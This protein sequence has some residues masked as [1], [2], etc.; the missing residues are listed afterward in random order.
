MLKGIQA[1][2]AAWQTARRLGLYSRNESKEDISTT[3]LKYMMVPY[4]LGE[5][6]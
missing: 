1:M 4:F 5:V 2:T 6:R 3:N